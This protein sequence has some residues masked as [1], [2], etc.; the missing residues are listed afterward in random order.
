ME[1][2]TWLELESASVSS[3]YALGNILFI[4]YIL[5]G[6]LIKKSRY[7]LAFFF[8]E[9]I[10]SCSLFDYLRE[11]QIYLTSFVVYSYICSH[12]VNRKTKLACGIMCLLDLVLSYDAYK[13]GIG[14]THGT[15][16]TVLYKN[17]QYLAFSANIIIIVSFVHIG[18]I[19]DSICSLFSYA[20]RVSERGSYLFFFCYNIIKT[21][22]SN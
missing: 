2:L 15:S 4:L 18:R 17:I 8:S 11:Y 14:G 20:F 12:C 7:L 16:E 10:I 19:F 3:G 6:V 22:Q 13:Y 5:T 9:F 1:L 21:Q